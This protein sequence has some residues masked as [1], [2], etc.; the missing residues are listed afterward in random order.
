MNEVATAILK[1]EQWPKIEMP[2]GTHECRPDLCSLVHATS[3]WVL[4]GVP[5]VW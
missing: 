3:L 5:T 2:R 4:W 1:F